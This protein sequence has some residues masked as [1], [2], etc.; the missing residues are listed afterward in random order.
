MGRRLKFGVKTKWVSVRVPESKVKIARILVREFVE[1]LFIHLQRSGNQVLE[2]FFHR[3]RK[4]L[5]P[6]NSLKF[7]SFNHFT[8]HK[9]EK[10][11]FQSFKRKQRKILGT[12]KIHIV[13][14]LNIELL[15]L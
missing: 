12:H 3:I 5:K 13:A 6:Q 8:T 7:R 10:K 9:D 2:I 1:I 4:M 11:E 14:K 15:L